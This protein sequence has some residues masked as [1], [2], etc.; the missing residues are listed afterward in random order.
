MKKQMVA[1]VVAIVAMVGGAWGQG[2]VPE[3]KLDKSENVRLKIT[4]FT[5][6]IYSQEIGDLLTESDFTLTALRPR[7]TLSVGKQWEAGLVINFA[8]FQEPQ[9]NWLREAYAA[10][11]PADKWKISVGRIFTAAGY[12]TPAPFMLETVSYPMADP[13]GAYG[14]GIG[15]EGDLGNGWLIRSSITGNSNVNFSDSLAFQQPEFS[16]RIEKAFGESNV[17]ATLQL[18]EQFARIG[19]DFTWKPVSQ[20]YLRGEVAYV[21]N[22]DIRTSDSI[23]AYVFGAYRPAKWFELH[24][25]IDGTADIQKSYYEWQVSKTDDGSVSID[26]VKCLTSDEVNVVWTTGM[27]IFAGKGDAFTVTADYEA[28]VYG[29]RPDRFLARVQFKF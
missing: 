4:G 21:R 24:S 7:L 26:R 13:F 27:R 22:A 23:G 17:A 29:T 25:Q 16:A 8:D 12:S 5:A 6:A 19:A 20:F 11:K 10:Y 28:S 2:L 18:S 14:W 9:G 1:M 15:L 3:I